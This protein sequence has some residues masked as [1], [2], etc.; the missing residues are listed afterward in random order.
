L[1][2]TAADAVTAIVTDG[3]QAAMNRFNR[4]EPEASEAGK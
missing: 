2:D 1:L 4:R 3:A